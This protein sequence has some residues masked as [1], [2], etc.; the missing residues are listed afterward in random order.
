MIWSL[1]N[2]YSSFLGPYEDD[3][4]KYKALVFDLQK[5][6]K[7]VC[8]DV[9]Y[10]NIYLLTFEN[11]SLLS[12][13]LYAYPNLVLSTDVNNQ[14]AQKAL[15]QIR[16]IDQDTVKP[17]LRFIS[18][19]KNMNIDLYS[20]QSLIIQK[21]SFL[22]KNMQH[23]AKHTMGN[24]MELLYSKLIEVSSNSWSYLQDFS[25]A[26]L[27]VDY[28]GEKIT[29]S[30]VRN[31]AYDNN[32][33]TRKDAYYAEMEAYKKI[34]SFV[35]LSINNIKR[36]ANI[37]A[38]L[39]KYKNPL[40]SALF[41]YKMQ[42]ETLDALISS[43]RSYRSIFAKYLKTK[44]LYLK[45]KNGLPFYDLFAPVGLYEKTYTF[46][47]ACDLVLSAFYSYSKKLGDFAKSYIDNKWIDVEPKQG[48]VGGAFCYPI[49]GIKESRILLNFTGSLSDCLTL[50]HE[51]GHGYH[52][53]IMFNNDPLN[54]GCPSELA[55]TAS[56]FCE[57]IVNNHLLKEIKDPMQRLSILESSVQDTTQ[58]IIDILS[59]FIFENNLINKGDTPL[60]VDEIKNLMIEAQKEAYLDGLDHNYLHPYMWLCKG[61]Y[62]GVN[63]N[64]Y[65]FPYA[66][67]LLYGVGLY[68]TYL[69]NK[70]SFLQRYDTMLALTAHATAEEIAL[71]MNID[72][73]KKDFWLKSLKQIK[74]NILEVIDLLKN[75]TL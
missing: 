14:E 62:Y 5:C 27:C 56:I 75:I 18:K 8:D 20:T 33:S 12:S 54:I 73:T 60:S 65:N 10:I 19:I 48:K 21:Y 37:I 3:T 51:L 42:K 40:S 50:A 9:T 67:G 57:T 43:M 1:N 61:H 58:V 59:R 28:L 7:L 29:L 71:T 15:A 34:D 26:N 6:S 45:H 46:K 25:T 64:Y 2:L 13:R 17:Y 66:F 30:M 55:E 49:S 68:S 11:I 70:E 53:F 23:E 47:E 72:I 36:E 44:A 63:S 32:P 16:Q 41:T 35:A 52:D 74:S 39:R 24:A 69:D 4:K 31:L 22:L 38:K